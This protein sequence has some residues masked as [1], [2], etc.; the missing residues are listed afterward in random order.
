MKEKYTSSFCWMEM[1]NVKVIDNDSYY[2][3]RYLT[4]VFNLVHY[5]RYN[6][7]RHIVFF[8]RPTYLLCLSQYFF[9]LFLDNIKMLLSQ[10]LPEPQNN[11]LVIICI[12]AWIRSAIWMKWHCH[13][14]VYMLTVTSDGPDSIDK[15]M[16]SEIK[17]R[18][19]LLY[20]KK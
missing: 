18:Y 16:Y 4:Q 11:P 10:I 9:N 2:F 7:L 12:T 1:T 14:I 8:N 15:N 13:Y 17:G 3:Q 20:C 19:W 6:G 5:S